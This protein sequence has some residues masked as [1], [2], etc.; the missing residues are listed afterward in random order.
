[1]EVRNSRGVMTRV[2]LFPKAIL[3]AEW[4][5]NAPLR[6]AMAIKRER[7]AG[8]EGEAGRSSRILSALLRSQPPR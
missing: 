3:E 7:F 5:A 4:E 8:P 6:E 2:M 1:M